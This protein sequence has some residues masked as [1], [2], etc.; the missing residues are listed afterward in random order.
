MITVSEL[1]QAV[2]VTPHAAYNGLSRREISQSAIDQ[3][4]CIT[5]GQFRKVA[6]QREWSL[7]WLVEQCK[8]EI[9]RPTDTIRRVLEGARVEGHRQGE[10]WVAPYWDDMAEVALPYRCL[11]ELYQRATQPALAG[12]RA[13]VCGCGGSL[14][15]RQKFASVA[16]RKRASRR[17]QI[18]QKRGTEVATD[19]A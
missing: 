11:I 2:G 9:D 6:R 13:C 1:A 16:C 5:F 8:A 10:R 18:R 15:G 19:A 14:R 7:E 3:A 17:G 12:G 4:P